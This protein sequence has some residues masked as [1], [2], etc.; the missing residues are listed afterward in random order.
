MPTDHPISPRHASFAVTRAPEAT[1]SHASVD[2]VVQ[3]G[4]VGT[5]LV[6]AVAAPSWSDDSWQ[7]FL[8]GSLEMEARMGGPAR[9]VLSYFLNGVPTASQRHLSVQATKKSRL[10]DRVALLSDSAL[11]RGAFNAIQ[12]VLGKETTSRAFGPTEVTVALEWLS[13]AHLFDLPAGLRLANSLIRAAH[14]R[15]NRPTV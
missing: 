2:G 4:R 5:L 1:E 15:A 6:I 12:W 14:A 8:D 7:E 13:M 10:A 3:Y 11:T 9:L